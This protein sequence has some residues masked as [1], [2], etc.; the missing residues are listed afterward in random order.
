M[1]INKTVL[2]F[3][4]AVLLFSN[5]SRAELIERDRYS[6]G[7]GKLSVFTNKNTVAPSRLE[8]ADVEKLMRKVEALQSA[9]QSNERKL[10]EQ[11]RDLRALQQENVRLTQKVDALSRQIK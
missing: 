2:L 10:A 5:V 9:Q 7:E 3:A 1:R 11:E 6:F 8:S 4:A